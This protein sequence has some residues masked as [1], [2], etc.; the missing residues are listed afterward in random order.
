MRTRMP[1]ISRS[2]RALAGPREEGREEDGEEDELVFMSWRSSRPYSRSLVVMREPIV[3][4]EVA[5]WASG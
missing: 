2:M 5:L 4:E 1:W 3:R